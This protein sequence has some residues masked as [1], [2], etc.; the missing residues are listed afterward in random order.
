MLAKKKKK[1]KKKEG[2][3]RK[4]YLFE[5]RNS[6]SQASLYHFSSQDFILT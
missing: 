5:V 2:S 1:K 4:F 3:G 6:M